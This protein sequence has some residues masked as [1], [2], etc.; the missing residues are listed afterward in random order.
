MNDDAWTWISGSNLSNQIGI[1][2]GSEVNS[3]PGGRFSGIAW[4]DSSMQV[5]WLF[6]GYGYDHT[7]ALGTWYCCTKF[8]NSNH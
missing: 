6:G 7:G 8:S 1:Y 3:A 5:L 4:Y 2:N